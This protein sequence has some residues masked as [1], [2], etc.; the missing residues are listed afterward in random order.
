MSQYVFWKYELFPYVCYS[1]I[2][3]LTKYYV[4]P[5]S[6]PYMRLS[7]KSDKCAIFDK[8]EAAII[9]EN[10]ESLKKKR[11]EAEQLFQNKANELNKG[12]FK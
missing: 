9:I 1:T 2:I 7:I 6:N 12:I 5:S 3:E 10:I 4:V 11:K 8:E